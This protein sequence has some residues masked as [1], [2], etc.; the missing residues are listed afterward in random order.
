MHLWSAIGNIILPH[1]LVVLTNQPREM[2]R[3]GRGTSPQSFVHDRM[4]AC[5]VSLEVSANLAVTHSFPKGEFCAF[6]CLVMV[7][8]A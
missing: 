3:S 4:D 5:A 7:E 2:D 1:L 6:S 8:Q